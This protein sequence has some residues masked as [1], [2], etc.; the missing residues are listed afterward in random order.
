MWPD[1][2]NAD[3]HVTGLRD[4]L[5]EQLGVA[6]RLGADLVTKLRELLGK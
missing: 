3:R 6:M 1:R 5:V 2:T 4:E